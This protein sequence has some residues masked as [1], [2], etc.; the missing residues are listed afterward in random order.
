M[1]I[2]VAAS[3][4]GS[5]YI[6][7]DQ[8]GTDGWGVQGQH[9]IKLHQAP[10]GWLGYTGSYRTIQVVRRALR[11]VETIDGDG[12]MEDLVGTIETALHSAGWSRSASGELPKCSDL[13]LLVVTYSGAIYTV[14]SDL[15]FL[16]HDH[17]AAVG[18]GYQVALGA[19]HVAHDRGAHPAVAVRGALG[20]ACD[21][22][23]SCAG[24]AEPVQ[25]WTEVRA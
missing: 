5:A 6:G 12:G 23:A 17:F 19:L 18:S 15:A 25:V 1:T 4:N 3:W 7:S 10:F 22:I 13:Y 21:I 11:Q 16:R 2:I 14:Q 8:A 20:A 9:G 24:P